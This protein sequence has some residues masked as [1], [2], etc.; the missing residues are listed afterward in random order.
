MKPQPTPAHRGDPL[1]GFT[2]NLWLAATVNHEA[3]NDRDAAVTVAVR[4]GSEVSDLGDMVIGYART[5]F[6]LTVKRD[7]DRLVW[8]NGAT[9]TFTTPAPP[10]KGAEP[11]V[12]EADEIRELL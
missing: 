2:K 5:A 11:L 6:G 10:V 4:S 9:A 3:M 8:P 12:I 1:F 7:G